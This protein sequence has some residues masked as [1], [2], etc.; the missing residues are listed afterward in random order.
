VVP[1]APGLYFVG[2]PFLRGF[3]SM[4]VGGVARDAE[5]VAGHIDRRA[6]REGV[7]SGSLGSPGPRVPDPR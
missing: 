6:V 1:D 3:Y 5:Y 4:L 7:A 2:L